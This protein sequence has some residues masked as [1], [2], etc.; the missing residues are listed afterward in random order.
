GEVWLHDDNVGL[1]ERDAQPI[2]VERANGGGVKHGDVA[3][4]GGGD[5][6]SS[7]GRRR[8]S[9]RNALV[10]SEIALALVLLVGAGLMI[11]SFTALR[12]V[13]PG[14]DP[15]GLVTMTVSVA[16]TA[17]AAPGMRAAFFESALDRVRAV[18]GVAAAGW[19]NHLPISGDEWGF[20]F[21]VEGQPAPKPGDSPHAAYR[22]V[23]SGYF[24]TMRIPFVAGRDIAPTDREGAAKVVV[25]N[26]FMAGAHWPGESAVGKRISF[27]GSTWVTVVGVVKNIARE[28]WA[29]PPREEVFVPYLQEQA[30]LAQ[31][32]S[33]FSYLTLVA[34]TTC[35]DASALATPIVNALRTA[36][37]GTPIS[38][39]ATMTAVVDGATADSR[40]Y[41]SFLAAFSMMAVVLA[42]VGIYGVM[43]YSVA[44]RTH[45]VGIRIALGA[46]PAAV[47]RDVVGAG[48]RLALVGA[49][50]GLVGAFALTRLMGN[51]LYGVSAVDPLTF[52]ATTLAL[53]GV[54]AAASYVPARRATRVSP[55]V[56][57]RAD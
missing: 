49:G 22:V 12:R 41:S 3:V 7:E 43:S 38:G 45:E 24:A 57:L 42:A 25:I 33:Q 4:C 11:R 27:D 34:R 35:C 2:S 55:L 48:M 44:R 40:F 47:L 20:S 1:G 21:T 16:G 13:D 46:Q 17:E 53:C 39:V 37:R 29:A 30:Y 10:V 51:L 32:G 26:E 15:R 9:L 28:T 5:R 52:A 36:D 18:P 56:A 54:A 6:A 19:V 50:I 23:F 8:A 31:P 14:F